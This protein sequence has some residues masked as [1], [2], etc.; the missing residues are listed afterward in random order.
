[1]IFFFAG[2]AFTIQNNELPD[3]DDNGQRYV[4]MN[5]HRC[6]FCDKTFNFAS[7]LKR[8]VRIHTGERPYKCDVCGMSFTCKHHLQH[9]L[10]SPTIHRRIRLET[11]MTTDIA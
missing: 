8:H 11:N 5:V 10:N 7:H 4:L 9:H 3:K 2:E 6:D 1:M